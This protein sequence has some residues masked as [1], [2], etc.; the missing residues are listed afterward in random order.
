M[1][2]SS[3]WLREWVPGA[4][5]DDALARLLTMAGLEVDAIEP[6]AP[7][8]SGVVVGRILA[9]EPHPDADKLKLC[10]VSD[11]TDEFNVVCGAPNAAAG[12][13][14]PYARPGAKLPGEVEIA[15]TEIRGQ[16]SAGMLCAADEL[17]LAEKSD[18]LLDLGELTLGQ[19]LR[20]ALGLADQIIE[21][22][23]TPNRS[24]CLGIRGIARETAALLDAPLTEPAFAPVPAVSEAVF[25]VRLDAPE[26]CPRYLGRV[27]E[28][29]D[30]S[31]PTPMWMVEKLRRSG[32]RS[33]DP[34]VD[35]TN[36]V[37]LE[38]GQPLHAFDLERLTG[39]IVVRW[40]QQGET[41]ELLDGNEITPDPET[42]LITDASGP[43]ALAGIMGGEKSAVN[44]ATR[45]LFL[46][47]ALFL[48]LPLAGK[49]RRYGMHTDASHR[50]E[51]GVDFE[52]QRLAIERATQL[53]L[54]ICGGEPG[55]VID[56]VEIAHL[57]A[58]AEIR[59]RHARVELLIG[60]TVPP[61][62]VEGALTR[63]GLEQLGRQGEGDAL[64]WTFRAP[65]HRY[66]LQIEEDL[67]EEVCRVRGYD[68][69]PVRA[70]SGAIRPG[71]HTETV[72]ELRRV[73]QL[74][75]AR[76][77]Q[78]AITYSFVDS[79]LQSQLE[80]QTEA[81]P[82]DNPIAADMDVMRVSLLP[83]LIGALRHNLA[84]QNL[85]VRLFETGRVFLRSGAAPTGID[86]P[87]RV[88]GLI[89]GPATPVHWH[90]PA[91]SVDFFD[92]KGDVE[93]L[94]ALR[95]RTVT[96]EPTTHPA[97][98]PGRSA[99]I[100]DADGTEIGI[101][102]ALHPALCQTLELP[103]DVYL[104]ELSLDSVS[105]SEVPR[106]R[107]VSR[108]PSSSRDIAVVVDA[109]LPVG[110]L[111]QAVGEACR[112]RLTEARIF[113]VYAGKGIDSAKKSVG[114]GL[115]FQDPSRTLKDAEV[116]DLVESAIRALRDRFGAELRS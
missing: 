35:I 38:L 65:S 20:E 1:K 78:E 97:L 94:L 95:R 105:L 87:R 5:D 16:Q 67:V 68:N 109:G 52:L 76:G 36:Y 64:C 30:L 42:L 92:L 15:A 79:R 46:E 98:H 104:F 62:D 61:A 18:G 41:L 56:A 91:R 33:I 22:D 86:Q 72:I 9:T 34:S 2:F 99:R 93:S 31:R 45:H 81:I 69:V 49:A 43:V 19:D 51:R 70:P 39:G 23:L 50:Y 13:C 102:G 71:C 100:V 26:A 85:R 14:V 53:V 28:N 25:P 6:A 77:Y 114:L 44:D 80:P 58:P 88:G 55:P 12:M 37:M 75:Q 32:V 107:V 40:P 115:T 60:D 8:F 110:S 3:S 66:D 27:I 17:G 11:G 108:F 101:L 90:T 21:L 24:D 103:S 82:L 57:P 113:D 74:L 48:P 29:I 47:C 59:L 106:Q 10:R 63:L 73:Q 54:D 116:S 4:P 83:G 7:P 89:H 112:E 96:F 84:H 111:L